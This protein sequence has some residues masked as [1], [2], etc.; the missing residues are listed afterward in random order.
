MDVIAGWTDWV[1]SM[2]IL[3]ADLKAIGIEATLHLSPSQS[4][5]GNRAD[6][7]QVLHFHWPCG[8]LDNPYSYLFN[9]LATRSKQQAPPG[10][11]VTSGCD[12]ERYADPKADP[13]FKAWRTTASVS[14]QKKAAAKLEQLFVKDLPF[15]P[16]WVNPV[17]YTYST[18]YFTNWPSPSNYYAI[19]AVWHFPDN[20]LVLA[21]VKPGK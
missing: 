1:L 19:G 21:N 3:A 10:Q 20:G 14:Q 4:D 2:Q 6:K 18:K 8:S 7:G 11:A 16:V 12:W 13:L 5:W 9:H 17:W 15:I